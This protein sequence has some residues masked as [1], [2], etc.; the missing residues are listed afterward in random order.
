M[1]LPRRRLC[2]GWV[3]TPLD[4]GITFS[5]PTKCDLLRHKQTKRHESND[6]AAKESTEVTQFL[7]LRLFNISLRNRGGWGDMFPQ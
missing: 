7:R 1:E 3:P 4:T 6:A 2:G 5:A